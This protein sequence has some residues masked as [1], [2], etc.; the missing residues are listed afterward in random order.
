M[1]AT[2]DGA[3]RPVLDQERR[4]VRAVLPTMIMTAMILVAA[5]CALLLPLNG[6]VRFEAGV[7]QTSPR[8]VADTFTHRPLAYRLIMSAVFAPARLLGESSRG[9]ELAMQASALLLC[10]LAALLLHRALTDRG[11]P[12]A[13]T[14]PLAIAVGGC[15]GLQGAVSVWEPDWLALLLTALAVSV[16]LLGRDDRRTWLPAA[17]GAGVLLAAAASIKFVTLPIALIGLVLITVLHRRRAIAATLAAGAAGI[18]GIGLTAWL[19]PRELRW[20]AELSALQ[21]PNTE[22]VWRALLGLGCALLAWPV[23][24]MLP[25]ALSV[26]IAGRP[27]RVRLG[28]GAVAA[29]V[30]LLASLPAV[31]QQQFFIYHFVAF[32]VITAAVLVLAVVRADRRTAARL[33]IGTA[34]AG[35]TTAVIIRLPAPWRVD[36]P[37]AFVTGLIAAMIIAVLIV[38]RPG[39]ASGPAPKMAVTAAAAVCCASMIGIVAPG[40]TGTAPLSEL[41][42]T[43]LVNIYTAEASDQRQESARQVRRLIGVDTPVLYLAFGDVN[44]FVRNPTPCDYPAAVWLQRARYNPSVVD[45]TSYAENLACLDDPAPRF[46]LIDGGWFQL[47]KQPDQVQRLITTRY[48]CTDARKI[49]DLL[50]CPRRP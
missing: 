39:R 42:Q 36:H 18:A 2:V 12:T 26:L 37:A 1:S 27:A 3:P 5:G 32:P 38:R 22:P 14:R 8:P 28:H 30:L 19:W 44:Y 24:I 13:T 4:S 11:L 45:T 46:L 49:D 31:V 6:D 47:P 9:F 25:A 43:G 50:I 20:L 41:P 33:V 40:P 7:E 23:T 15:I 21:P 17:V 34:L 35:L 10:V 29:V 16:G 48:A